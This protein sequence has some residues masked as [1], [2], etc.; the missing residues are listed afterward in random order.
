MVDDD[1]QGY[2]IPGDTMII[3]NI[4]YS[5]FSVFKPAYRVLLTY[6]NYR[7]MTRNETAYPDPEVFRPERFM[8]LTGTEADDI[9]PRRIIFGFGRRPV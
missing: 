8:G 2:L 9:D 5:S 6:V 4:W 1:Y 3:P 7:G